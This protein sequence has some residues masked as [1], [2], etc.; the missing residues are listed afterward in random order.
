VRAERLIGGAA[1]E[2][3]GVV[4]Y[5]GI[6]PEDLAKQYGRPLSEEP[7]IH[8]TCKIYD[9]H[10]GAWTELMENTTLV[11]STF[12]D[13]SYTAGDVSII[14][15]D[16]GKFS[17]IASHVRINP[18]NHPMQRVTLHHMTY[19]RRRYLLGEDDDQEF[20]QWRRDH[21]CTIGHDTWLGHGA[22]VL[23]GIT[24]GNG[25]VIA[26]GAVVSKD[27]PAYTIVGGVPAKPIKRRFTEDVAEKIERIAWWD[28]DRATIEARFDDLLDLD[29]FLEKYAA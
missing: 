21:R 29:T 12:G 24:V 14:Y 11:E 20:F 15:T 2:R 13:Y 1:V 16:V 19:R 3:S 8:P 4:K 5:V 6:F 18:G 10:V 23:P 25:A 7:T 27:V 17:N 9:S 26:A 22:I 28:W